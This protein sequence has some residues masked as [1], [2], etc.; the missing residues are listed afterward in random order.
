[1]KKFIFGFLVIFYCI[2]M[3]LINAQSS[4]DIDLHNLYWTNRENFLKKETHIQIFDHLRGRF[5]VLQ[6]CSNNI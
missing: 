5:L 1:M 6:F 4:I 2:A 3:N